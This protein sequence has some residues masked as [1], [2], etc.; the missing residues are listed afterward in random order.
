MY[1]HWLALHNDVYTG[2]PSKALFC[3]LFDFNDYLIDTN[4]SKSIYFYLFMANEN[5]ERFIGCHI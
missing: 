4:V 2:A 1:T 5:L 3:V